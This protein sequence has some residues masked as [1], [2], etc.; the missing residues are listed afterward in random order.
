MV[1]CFINHNS[2][3]WGFLNSFLEHS[4]K[5][6]TKNNDNFPSY[7]IVSITFGR[8]QIL[9]YEFRFEKRVEFVYCHILFHKPP[10]RLYSDPNSSIIECTRKTGSIQLSLSFQELFGLLILVSL[11]VLMLRK[12]SRLVFVRG[13]FTSS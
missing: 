12:K 10:S 9:T 3:K 8:S 13:P 7:V 5:I 1:R 4:A 11:C 2:K 6:L